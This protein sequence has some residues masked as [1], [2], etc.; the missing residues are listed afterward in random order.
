[1]LKLPND[2]RIAGP[3]DGGLALTGQSIGMTA[4]LMLGSCQPVQ[5]CSIFALTQ[6]GGL[7][8][9]IQGAPFATFQTRPA[10]NEE[11]Q[12]FLG[13]KNDGLFRIDQGIAN[14]SLLDG[15]QAA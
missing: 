15:N 8:Q 14:V 13:R 12:R 5:D 4:C 7:F 10:P 9:V 2:F 6:G 11:G 3:K 1:M